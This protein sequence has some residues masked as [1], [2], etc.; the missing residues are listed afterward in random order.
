VSTGV[1]V[2]AASLFAEAAEGWG[3]YRQ[4]L[5]HALALL[6]QGRCLAG[7]GGSAG[8]HVLRVAHDRLKAL[9]ARPSAAEAA[10]LLH[11]VAKGP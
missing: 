4:V 11:G 6:G 10:A 5:E 7:M 9:G 2:V 8:E 3:E 1:G